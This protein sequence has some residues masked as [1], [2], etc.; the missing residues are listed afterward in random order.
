MTGTSMMQADKTNSPD[1]QKKCTTY[2]WDPVR[3]GRRALFRGAQQQ[4]SP[5]KAKTPMKGFACS[6]AARGEGSLKV[7]LET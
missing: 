2:T 3:F 4:P 1:Q 6:Q 7:D 5:W